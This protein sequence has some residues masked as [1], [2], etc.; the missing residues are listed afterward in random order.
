MDIEKELSPEMNRALQAL[1]LSDIEEGMGHNVTRAQGLQEELAQKRASLLQD[2][3]EAQALKGQEEL[4]AEIV[5]EEMAHQTQVSVLS[6]LHLRQSEEI[7]AQSD[8]IKRLSTLL[9]KQQTLL[10][11]V[12]ESRKQQSASVAQRVQPPTSR[13]SEL[14]QEAFQYLPGT[15]NVRHGTRIQH[16]SSISQNIPVAGRQH[17]EDELAEE[18]TWGSNHPCHV[19]FAGSEKGGFTSTPLKSAAE[20]GEDSSLL[21]QQKQ[22]RQNLLSSTVSQPIHDMQMAACEFHKLHKP[23]INKLKGGYSAMA[24]LIFQSWLKDIRVHVE[25]RNLTEREA[26]QLVKDFTAERACDEVEFYMGM[27]TDEQQTFKG[28]V[29]HLKNAFQ[30]GETTSKLISNFYARA[31]KKNE[32]E[33][34]FADELQILVCK[35]IARKPEFREDANEQLKSQFM[36]KL[37]DPYYAVIPRSML[38][39]SGDSESFTQFRGCLAMMFGGRSKSG[40]TSSHTAAIETSS[41]VISKEA[42]EHRLSKK[43]TQRQQKIEQQASQISSLEAQNKK[44]GQLLEP[45]FLVE[46]ITRVVASNLNM[47]KSNTTKGSPSGFISKPY[48]GRSCP[49]QY[50]PGVD[51]SLDL[52][53]TCRYCKDPG[54]LK[55]NCVKLTQCLAW[56]KQEAKTETNK[57]V[58]PMNKEN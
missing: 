21:P 40:K 32:S 52:S 4:L 7:R 16:L 37:K 2:S 3:A 43:S 48:L 36:H 19:H 23:K 20:V 42:G 22:A 28:L 31:Q 51:G 49:S 8:E 13:L 17:F 39:S 58:P 12:Q 26:M 47:D 54:H 25:D 55:E 11:Q 57:N 10:E 9:E 34:A 27:V 5:K 50:A 14:Q 29:Q 24:N 6:H 1:A 30:S 38:Q 35:I 45:K 41:Y 53:L 18:A 46:T 33:E 56:N 44:L 15:V